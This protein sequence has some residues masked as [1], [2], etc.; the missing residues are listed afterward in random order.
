MLLSIK[1]MLK[2]FQAENIIY[3]HWK[4]NEH[5]KEA[6]NGD[7]DLDMLFYPSQRGKI[8][9]IL[10]RFNLKRFR[11]T[12]HMQYN[13][14]EDFIGFDKDMAK[15]WH[16]HLHYKLT[17]GEKHL[18]GYTI[19][20]AS[21]ILNN[22]VYDKNLEV[23][24]SQPEYEYFLIL[25]RIALKL[26]W[27]DYNRKIGKD[28]I[29]EINWL[30]ERAE[31]KKIVKIA[32][33]YLG[34]ECA[35]E[36]DKLLSK[37]LYSNKGLFKLQRILRFSMKYYTSYNKF[38]SYF[39]RTVREIF[40][41]FGGISRRLG[42]NSTIPSRRISPSG[43]AVVAILGCDGAGKSTT[44]KYIVKEFGKKIDIKD[45]Y[46]GS[47]DGSSSILRYPMKLVAKKISGRGIGST[48]KKETGESSP[49]KLSLKA[50]GYSF[51]KILWAITLAAEKKKKLKIIT[52]AR[53][54]G[55]L[56]LTDRYPQV[57]V[58]GYNDGP[59]LS[60]YT[61]SSSF[62]LR[63]IAKWEV[64]IYKSAYINPP[65]LVIKLMVPTEVAIERKPEM[66]VSEIENKKS[67]VKKINLSPN[68]VEIDTFREKNI[69]FGEVMEK[70]WEIV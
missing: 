16:L 6:L 30:R 21:Y 50:K 51:A 38:K 45:I 64:S 11:A 5:L 4:S 56:V 14:I 46:L 25:L 42:F 27:R 36:Y 40:W 49:K 68:S 28:D 3:C 48:I 62:I 23:F 12:T 70:I 59:L 9:A 41:L 58:M 17:L 69:S 32:K 20:W 47:G 7:T 31:N 2:A 26:R 67:A 53:N 57:E 33:M 10:N 63:K 34:E 15:I 18:K 19:P 29:K 65:D 54:N 61:K 13:A 8:E 22:R 37:N 44:L 1:N 43:G 39:K 60:R 52:K 24:C 66:T 55:I 35:K